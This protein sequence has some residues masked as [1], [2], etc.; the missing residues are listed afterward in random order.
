MDPERDVRIATRTP[1]IAAESSVFITVSSDAPRSSATVVNAP[2]STPQEPA[3][4]AAT[5]QQQAIWD[6]LEEYGDKVNDVIEKTTGNPM[7]RVA[8]EAF[9]I[10]VGDEVKEFKGGYY[11][12]SYDSEERSA[13]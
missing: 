5:I 11:P 10:K 12:I 8:P 9:K 3:V 6:H 7:K 13:M 1:D 4:G 2:G